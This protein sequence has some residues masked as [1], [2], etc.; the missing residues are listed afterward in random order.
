LALCIDNSRTAGLSIDTRFLL[1]LATSTGM[2][3]LANTP[4]SRSPIACSGY[5]TAICGAVV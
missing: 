4:A 1:A 5:S 2:P 3:C